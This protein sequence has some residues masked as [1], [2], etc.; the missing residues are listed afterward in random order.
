[1]SQTVSVPLLM[2]PH[3]VSVTHLELV[4]ASSLA[5][6][7][8]PY[9]YPFLPFDP[10]DPSPAYPQTASSHPCLA[11]PSFAASLAFVEG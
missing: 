1:M 11:S 2:S 5:A 9:P 8:H 10:S 7:P 3:S 4:A 6:P